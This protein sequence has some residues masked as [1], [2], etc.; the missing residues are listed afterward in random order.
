M[1]F[2]A[3]FSGF[4]FSFHGWND[5]QYRFSFLKCLSRSEILFVFDNGNETQKIKFLI[6]WS[7][8]STIYFLKRIFFTWRCVSCV[9]IISELYCFI[10]IV[11]VIEIIWRK[12]NLIA[13]ATSSNKLLFHSIF[14]TSNN[15]FM[16][17]S[18]LLVLTVVIKLFNF[19][20]FT[21]HFTLDSWLRSS[22]K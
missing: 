20:L 2:L 9:K 5:I 14:R 21:D 7:S 11:F 1:V 12:K 13:T 16:A 3:H 15:S 17:L 6:P 18:R 19:L 8:I 10:F 22:W 4:V